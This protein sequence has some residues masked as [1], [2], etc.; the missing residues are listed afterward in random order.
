MDTKNQL[1]VK[2]NVL[3]PTLSKLNLNELRLLSF[4][5]S[6]IDRE[7]DKFVPL[8]V[9]AKELAETFDLTED[10]IYFLVDDLIKRINSKPVQYEERVDDT[11]EKVTSVWYSTLRYSEGKGYFIFKMNDDLKPYV[12]QL[13]DNF[14]SYRIRD[15]YQFK[16]AST[17]HVYEVLKQYK[18]MKTKTFDL[19]QFKVLIGVSSKYKRF[20]NLKF[21]LI[22]NAIEEINLYSDI[23]VQC[24]YLKTGVNVT[25]LKFFIVDNERTKTVVEKAKRRLAKTNVINLPEL[26]KELRTTYK[27]NVKQAKDTANLVFM[28]KC[29]AE[30]R[31]LLPKLRK[32]YEALVNPRK[33]LGSYVF[34]SLRDFLSSKTL[35]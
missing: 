29:E 24:E 11:I 8:K 30:V 6:K 16:S 13:R 1:I 20:N 27:V 28:N 12:L 3:V 10:R 35:C 7:T 31:E 17:W 34:A 22:E 21:K 15:V 9:K 2:A 5:I 26:S 19:D 4:C 33:T 32:Q 23:K 18:S 14:T 25:G